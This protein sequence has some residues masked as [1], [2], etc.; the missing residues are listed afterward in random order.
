MRGC[1]GIWKCKWR[2]TW[3]LGEVHLL[4]VLSV[5]VSMALLQQHG[6]SFAIVFKQQNSATRKLNRQI[7]LW[8][9]FPN[10]WHTVPSQVSLIP[11]TWFYH[12]SCKNTFGA[13]DIQVLRRVVALPPSGWPCIHTEWVFEVH[14]CNLINLKC[15]R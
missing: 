7:V 5:L 4:S 6:R 8:A 10:L 13:H 9:K 12:W 2:P 1:R 14:C 15:H 11:A 3:S